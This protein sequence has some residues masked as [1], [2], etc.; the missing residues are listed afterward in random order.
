MGKHYGTYWFNVVIVWLM[1]LALY[2]TLYYEHLLKLINAFEK[3]SIRDIIKKNKNFIKKFR[4]KEK[5]D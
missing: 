4:K 5:G 3:V 2:L 1:T